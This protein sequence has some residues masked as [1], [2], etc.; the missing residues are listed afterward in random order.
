MNMIPGIVFTTYTFFVT[1]KCSKYA[2]VLQY[3]L[4]ERLTRDKYFSL[5]D[6]YISYNENEV[7]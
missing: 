2:V 3:T 4:L 5:L 7:F 1:Y 6:P